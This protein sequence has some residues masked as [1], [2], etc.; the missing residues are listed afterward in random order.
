M[1]IADETRM[2]TKM[3]PLGTLG[4]D[5]VTTPARHLVKTNIHF[6]REYYRVKHEDS[7]LNY[8]LHSFKAPP[9][10]LYNVVINGVVS[11]ELSIINN[12]GS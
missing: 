1:L 6:S 4:T 12:T 9:K 3:L 11:S 5:V 10:N 8:I 2:M 7:P